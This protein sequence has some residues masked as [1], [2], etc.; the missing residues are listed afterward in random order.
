MKAI[1]WLYWIAKF[2]FLQKRAVSEGQEEIK[3][4]TL[5]EDNED[6]IMMQEEPDILDIEA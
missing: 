4:E 6:I 5:G 1:Y 3:E 2:Y